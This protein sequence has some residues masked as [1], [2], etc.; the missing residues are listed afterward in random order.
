MDEWKALVKVALEKQPNKRPA[1][2]DESG[3]TEK[4]ACTANDGRP[5]SQ[6]TPRHN[7][8]LCRSCK[9]RQLLKEK[10]P[11]G[12]TNSTWRCGCGRHKHWTERCCGLYFDGD[13]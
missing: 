9:T 3:V 6:T 11:C 7:T 5:E 12:C 1:G 10:C 2:D 13:E 4:R 8:W